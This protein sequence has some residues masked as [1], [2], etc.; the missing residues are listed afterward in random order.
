MCDVFVRMRVCVSLCVCVCVP[1]YINIYACVWGMETIWFGVCVCVC[2]CACVCV[3][4]LMRMCMCVSM[5]VWCVCKSAYVS[6]SLSVLVMTSDHG[7][8]YM[9]FQCAL[10]VDCSRG[11][12]ARS[13]WHTWVWLCPC[14]LWPL[15]PLLA[16]QRSRVRL[17]HDH[18]LVIQKQWLWPVKCLLKTPC[19]KKTASL[20]KLYFLTCVQRSVSDKI[21]GFKGIKKRR[22][23]WRHHY[24]CKKCTVILPH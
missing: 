5:H 23:Y 13:G 4:L 19:L 21:N 2:V 12:G 11:A 14:I 9:S 7:V 22:Y 18:M 16:R 17:E 8:K 6:V 24:Y 3:H 10:F 20:W 15:L 1:A